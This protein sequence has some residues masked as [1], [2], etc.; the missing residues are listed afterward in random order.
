VLGYSRFHAGT[1]FG[2]AH[3]SPIRAAETG[4]VI[5]SGWYGGYGNTVILDHGGGLTTLYGH[6]SRLHV[7]EGDTVKKGDTIAAIGTTGLSTG[8]HLHFEV[9]KGGEPINPMGFL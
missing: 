7:S 5:M 3:G 9:R 6:A 8:P 1:D 2:A 4:V